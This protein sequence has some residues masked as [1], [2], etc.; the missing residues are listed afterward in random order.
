MGKQG[1]ESYGRI[2]AYI[3]KKVKDPSTTRSS[4]WDV[5]TYVHRTGG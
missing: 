3:K 5:L 4:S 1:I 2:E